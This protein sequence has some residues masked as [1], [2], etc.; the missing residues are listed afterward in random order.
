MPLRDVLLETDVI[1]LVE[2]SE[3]KGTTTHRTS[4]KENFSE[5]VVYINDIKARVISTH[6]G[7]FASAEFVTKY[8][9]TLVKGVWAGI[10]GSGLERQM[11]SGEKYVLM[12][13]QV[14]GAYNLQRSEKTEK[15]DDILRL[16]KELDNE[17]RRVA[18]AQAKIPNGIYHYSD[19]PAA[20]KVR[21]E[22]GRRM[23]IGE[24][25][26]FDIIRKDLN[27]RYNLILLTLT[28]GLGKPGHCVL[29][30]DGKAYWLFEHHWAAGEKVAGA[31]G[32][33]TLYCSFKD[34]KNAEA[35]ATFLGVA[36]TED[37]TR[38]PKGPEKK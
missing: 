10:P 8:S 30:V 24:Q 11:V 29:M 6:F 21:L 36:I 4:A 22:D 7:E 28:L 9:M 31:E 12:L 16:R 27:A 26:D 33:P 35:V 17:D 23:Q 1:I 37:Q 5:A 3:N 32:P 20:R 2:I 14:D 38:T 13:R 34:R 19:A 18:E 15:L 25:C